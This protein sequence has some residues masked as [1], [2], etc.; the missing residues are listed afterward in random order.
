MVTAQVKIPASGF[1]V[2]FLPGFHSFPYC[3]REG[4]GG[5]VKKKTGPI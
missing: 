1:E 5:W 3:L 2:I 4:V